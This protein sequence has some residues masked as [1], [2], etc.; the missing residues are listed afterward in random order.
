L[1]LAGLFGTTAIFFI[2]ALTG[3]WTS[4]L[5]FLIVLM[6]EGVGRWLFYQSR[7]VV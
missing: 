2:P 7:E 1:I 4:L 5:I 3:F 6:E